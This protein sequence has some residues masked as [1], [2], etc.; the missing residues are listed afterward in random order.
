MILLLNAAN[1]DA[2]PAL[3]DDMFR[4]RHEVFVDL[5]GWEDLRRPDGRETDPWDRADSLYLLAVE[6]ERVLGGARFTGGGEATLA[7][8][9]LPELFADAPPLGEDF[10]EMSRLFARSQV[11]VKD[12]LS[13]VI[14]ELL[15]A[16]AE[17][18]RIVG[19]RGALTIMELRL[20]QSMLAWG[21]HPEPLG[22]PLRTRDGVLVGVMAH[23]TAL[24]SRN[25]RRARGLKGPAIWWADGPDA[26]PVLYADVLRVDPVS[27]DWSPPQGL[28]PLERAHMTPYALAE[29]FWRTRMT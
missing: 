12:L 15:V 25:L 7:G 2:F 29:A 27:A 28:T 17:L 19:G 14:S 26:A 16:A 8:E 9:I 22:L 20:A 5:K 11:V 21:G 13:P 1:R 3:M 10:L 24:A 18:Q 23:A 6:G 4:I